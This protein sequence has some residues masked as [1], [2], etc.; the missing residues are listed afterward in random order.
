MSY[1]YE[2]EIE[3]RIKEYPWKE[4]CDLMTWDGESLNAAILDAV[5]RD[6]K[7]PLKANARRAL[8]LYYT[9]DKDGVHKVRSSGYDLP[10]MEMPCADSSRFPQDSGLYF[11]GM[12]GANP[13]GKQYYLV[14]VGSSEN[15]RSRLRQYAT[16]NPM[17]YIGGFCSFVDNLKEG[18]DN[19]HE[20]LAEEAIAIAQ[21]SS[22]WF[23]VTEEKYYELCDT[24]SNWQ[25]FKAIAEGRD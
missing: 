5:F 3:E 17:I 16:Y 20:Y 18:E 10:V 21:N 14:K 2:Q 1:K 12:I 6:F 23:Y 15:L 11:V 22:E 4:M 13:E 9:Y 24:F 7:A 19:V 25:T 8:E